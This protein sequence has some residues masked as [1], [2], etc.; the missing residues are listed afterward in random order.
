M[1]YGYIG[2]G[3]LG[4]HLAASL[5][6]DGHELVVHDRDPA[7]AERH[8]AMGAK[9]AASPAEVAEL[10]TKIESEA[11]LLVSSS[12]KIPGLVQV[13]APSQ[14]KANTEA[15][16]RG[17][18]KVEADIRKAYGT[19]SDLWRLIR[20]QSNKGTADNFWA[21]MKLGRWHQAND[22]ALRITGHGL[23]V[24][25]GGIEHQRR[26]NPRT[27]RV[28]GGEQP[29]DKRLFLAPTQLKAL[30]AYIKQ[31]QARVGLLA[32]GWSAAAN[33]LDVPVAAWIARHGP[34][35][36]SV[37]IDLSGDR[38][39][40]IATNYA[41][42]LPAGVRAELKRRLV[43]AVEYQTNTMER[44]I[45]GYHTRTRQQLGIAGR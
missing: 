13:T 41:P 2:L 31:Q 26:R 11:R 30:D 29:R 17:E 19:P 14:G 39:S 20:D 16:R 36:G 45:A 3:N 21:Y 7:L 9:V 8:R 5:I 25:D 44:A 37:Q 22:L 28:I 6:R 24:F 12:G 43:K 4:G 23:D 32:S 10:Q 15:K 18:A 33:A 34:T 35:T 42:G 27:G 40:V 1:K 38:M